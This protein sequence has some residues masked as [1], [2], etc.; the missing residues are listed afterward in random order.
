[1]NATKSTGKRWTERGDG[2]EGRKKRQWKMW[3]ENAL[4]ECRFGEIKAEKMHL[5]QFSKGS[6]TTWSGREAK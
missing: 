1:M 3:K 6:Q 5:P 2:G 4:A